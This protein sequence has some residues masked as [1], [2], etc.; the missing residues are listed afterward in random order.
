M[1]KIKIILMGIHII[2]VVQ[3]LY[4]MRLAQSPLPSEDIVKV[5][6][7]TNIVPATEQ[8]TRQREQEEQQRA[9]RLLT[10]RYYESPQWDAEPFYSPAQGIRSDAAQAQD[11]D[12][13]EQYTDP[14][15]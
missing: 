12:K 13:F 1:N 2:C 8:L 14:L 3:V 4:S 11:P 5:I 7:Q 9:Q 15:G 6:P 10:R